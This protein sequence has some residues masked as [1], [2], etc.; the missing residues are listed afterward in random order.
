M[1]VKKKNQGARKNVAFLGRKGWRNTSLENIDTSEGG[2]RKDYRLVADY[3][4]SRF[5]CATSVA[6]KRKVINS[7]DAYMRI[8]DSLI[9]KMK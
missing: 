1:S 8:I 4:L 9:D 7:L 5:D 6:E 3:L 2:L